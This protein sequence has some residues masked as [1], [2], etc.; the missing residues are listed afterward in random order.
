M[1]YVQIRAFPSNF[2]DELFAF[3]EFSVCQNA[4]TDESAEEEFRPIIIRQ[5]TEIIS[6]RKNRLRRTDNSSQV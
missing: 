4:L 1:P 2:R 3:D 5:K 6:R